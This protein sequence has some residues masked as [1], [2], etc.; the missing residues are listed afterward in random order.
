[1]WSVTSSG[2]GALVATSKGMQH[3]KWFG[4][5]R[6]QL[7]GDII[8]CQLPELFSS[9]GSNPQLISIKVSHF[10]NRKND[11]CVNGSNHDFLRQGHVRYEVC[12]IFFVGAFFHANSSW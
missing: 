9:A 7:S 1:M 5:L 12:V 8:N 4:F 10:G 3:R 11:I 2:E 6:T